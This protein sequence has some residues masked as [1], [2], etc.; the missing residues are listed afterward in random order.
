L[1]L[2]DELITQMLRQRKTA[3]ALNEER[4]DDIETEGS[5]EE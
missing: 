5:E 4:F 2:T 3:D 1:I